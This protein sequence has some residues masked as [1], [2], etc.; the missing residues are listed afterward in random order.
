MYFGFVQGILFDDRIPA[1]QSLAQLRLSTVSP[2]R[3]HTDNI[4]WITVFILF[5]FCIDFLMYFDFLYG[6]LFDGRIITRKTLKSHRNTENIKNRLDGTHV[7]P[8]P[9]PHTEPTEINGIHEKGGQGRDDS[10]SLIFH[11]IPKNSLWRNHSQLK[12]P[13]SLK[14]TP[15][16]ISPHHS[17]HT[18]YRKTP[19]D[20]PEPT[21]A[22]ARHTPET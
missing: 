1:R 5:F 9:I 14:E 20:P 15:A 13:I 22:S 12:F 19:S 17:R 8:S 7:V 21:K 10:T 3:H 4:R 6:I 18:T 11:F 16:K 2:T